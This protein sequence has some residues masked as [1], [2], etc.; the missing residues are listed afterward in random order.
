MVHVVFLG[1][2]NLNDSFHFAFQWTNNFIL[3]HVELLISSMIGMAFGCDVCV[4]GLGGV[5]L[6]QE[7]CITLGK[8]F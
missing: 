4:W 7:I 8:F 3:V 5:W 6:G 2:Q 1:L